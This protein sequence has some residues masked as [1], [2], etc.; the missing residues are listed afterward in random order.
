MRPVVVVPRTGAFSRALLCAC[1]LLAPFDVAA[2]T[3]P[4]S[5]P[6][7]AQGTPQAAPRSIDPA[8]LLERI[9]SA[10]VTIRRSAPLVG[11]GPTV[12][13]FVIGRGQIATSVSALDATDSPELSWTD[14]A[15]VDARGLIALDRREGWAI[16][17]HAPTG[18]D[19]LPRAPAAFGV[20][21]RCFVLGRRSAGGET[22]ASGIV[23]LGRRLDGLR[24]VAEFSGARPVPGAPILNA[25]GE[26]AGI[27]GTWMPQSL[28]PT[29][30]VLEL[31]HDRPAGLST[32]VIPLPP[33][34]AGLRAEPL[35]FE[36]LRRSGILVEPVV[37]GHVSG[38]GFSQGIVKSEK[39]T[40]IGVRDVFKLGD[41]ASLHAY[42][43][44]AP[45]TGLE[46]DVFLRIFDEHNT[47]VEQTR[48]TSMKFKKGTNVFVS[49]N[50]PLP[51]RA[52]HYRFDVS[53]GPLVYWRSYATV[54]DP[55]PSLGP[56]AA[57]DDSPPSGE[58][59]GQHPN[60][61]IVGPPQKVID[62]PPSYP[63][64]AQKAKVQGVVVIAASIDAT[65]E[66]INARVLK[67]IPSLDHAA[68]DA[69]RRWRFTATLVNGVPVPVTMTVSS[70]FSVQ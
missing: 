25:S 57:K 15:K 4:Q 40:P 27:A 2:Q 56:D 48:S 9:R 49:W 18:P 20:G 69:V 41:V 22:V 26:V 31:D 42:L 63:A 19:P 29:Q 33:A 11:S 46:G 64:S 23:V 60:D 55:E 3:T 6:P 8:Q 59:S 45:T 30:R 1:S 37:P 36:V 66:V 70:R 61:R 14:G 32:P 5:V 35:S 16:V 7:A 54:A 52:G 39:P 38:G 50:V 10:S 13:G 34:S 51:N 67:S 44:W 53:I 58:P 28:G 17:A 24:C 21:D 62:V 68:L 47:L 12:G 65:G 43:T